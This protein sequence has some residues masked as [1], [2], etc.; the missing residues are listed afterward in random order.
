MSVKIIFGA[1]GFPGLPPDPVFSLLHDHGVK[2]LDTASLYAGSEALL[3]STGASKDFTIHTK[4]PGFT[5]GSLSRRSVEDG[6]KKSLEELKLNSVETYFLHCPDT[7]TPIE[8]TLEAIQELYVAGKFRKFGLSNFK[9]SD[10]ES[11][12]NLAK[13]KGY[14]L[15]T[16]YQGN[17]N[18]VSRH[19]EQDLFPLLRKLNMSFWAYSPIAGGFLVRSPQAIKEGN[20]GRFDKE[21]RLGKMYHDLYAKP[22]LISALE[23]WELVAKKVGITKAALAYRW[24]RFNSALQGTHED[25]LILGASSPAQLEQT[26]KSLAEGPLPQEVLQDIENIWETV[27]HEAPIDNYHG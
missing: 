17:Y 5:P 25:A 15:P 26:L 18:A 3:G 10:V 8:E 1:A 23:Q 13:E 22:S 9:A 27:K 2:D 24:V 7:Q 14:V 19:Y 11:I 20:Q 16:V 4:A 6:M 21:T 12:Y